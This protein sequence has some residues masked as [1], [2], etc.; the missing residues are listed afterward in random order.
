MAFILLEYMN[1]HSYNIVA[2]KEMTLLKIS[3]LFAIISD[4]TRLKIMRSL[5]DNSLCTCDCKSCGSCEHLN[6]M[7][8]KSV[9]EIVLDTG[10][11][12]SLVSHQLKVLKDADL[13]K[14]RKDGQKVFY[15][16]NDGHV[17]ALLNVAIEHVEE[18]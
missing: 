6:C 17:K 1:G 11:S 12:Q 5:L 18:K 7:V 9:N 10:A 13:V 15:S 3:R 2:M 4:P 8:E 14:G 16:L